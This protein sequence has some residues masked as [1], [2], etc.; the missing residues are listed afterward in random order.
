MTYG[1]TLAPSV[2]TSP[3]TQSS[4]HLSQTPAGGHLHQRMFHHE[5]LRDVVPGTTIQP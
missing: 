3:I 2:G 4:I 1:S 5:W